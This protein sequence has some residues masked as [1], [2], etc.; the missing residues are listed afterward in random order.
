VSVET[1]NAIAQAFRKIAKAIGISGWDEKA[2]DIFT[3]VCDWLRDESN[4]PWTKILDNVDYA[5]VLTASVPKVTS[6]MDNDSDVPLP[7]IREFITTSSRGSILV[8]PRNTE[9]AQMITGN[10]AHHIEVEEMNETEAITL[11]RSKLSS[12]VIHSASEASELVKAVDNMSLAIS[13]IATNISINYPRLTL[14]KAI[15][16]INTPS[17]DTAQ[18]LETSVHETSRDIRR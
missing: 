7:Q 17:E 14:S 15:T 13:Q 18:L 3:L 1:P 6:L 11:L 5:N 8:T 2:T 10:C 9:A 16:Q 12:K 4:E